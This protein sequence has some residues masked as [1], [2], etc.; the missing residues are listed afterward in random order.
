M[1]PLY[2]LLNYKDY[3]SHLFYDMENIKKTVYAPVVSHA[4]LIHFFLLI[5]EKR[6]IQFYAMCQY[7]I[8]Q[9]RNS[10]Q[11]IKYVMPQV[12]R[13]IFFAVAKRSNGEYLEAQKYLKEALNL[14][15]PDKVYLPFAQQ[16]CMIE[17][18]SELNT[19]HN[20]TPNTRDT[21]LKPDFFY[22]KNNDFEAI[23]ELSK[24]QKKGVDIIRKAIHQ[25]RS[26]LTPREREIALLAKERL[27]AKEI[28][29]MLYISDMTVKA[30]LRSV[31][32]KLDVHSKAELNLKEF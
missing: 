11:N 3:V 30:T 7:E 28:A 23:I 9:A 6:Y 4:Q 10:T 5:L 17:F 25:G 26:P 21:N 24:R 19:T 20:N 15:L 32:S 22:D 1:R 27:S 14:A 16:E 31:Y 18:L 13:L 8:D 2:F 12:Y 29:D